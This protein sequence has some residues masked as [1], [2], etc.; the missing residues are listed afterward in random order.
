MFDLT[1]SRNTQQ[2]DFAVFI[3]Y[4]DDTGIDLAIQVKQI[5]EKRHVHTFV[6]E[7]DIPKTIRRL[8]DQWRT[9]IDN[10]MNSCNTVI[11]ILSGLNATQEMTR[12][13]GLAIDRKKVDGKLSFIICHFESIPR[14][15]EDIL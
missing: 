8:T 6:A 11:I 14:K 15:S 13:I 12:E 7:E 5:L 10:A 2:K 3:V 1:F 9:Q 4:E